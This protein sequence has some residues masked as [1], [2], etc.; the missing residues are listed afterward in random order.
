MFKFSYRTC[1]E[2]G[3]D[4]IFPGDDSTF[5]LAQDLVRILNGIPHGSLGHV[6]DEKGTSYLQA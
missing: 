2:N 6:T 4:M 5:A 1:S 3:Q